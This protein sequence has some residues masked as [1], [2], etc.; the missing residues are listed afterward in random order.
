MADLLP[1]YKT[2]LA[3]IRT[4]LPRFHITNSQIEDALSEGEANATAEKIF[5]AKRRS[6]KFA[7][8]SDEEFWRAL[9]ASLIQ[10]AYESDTAAVAETQV[11]FDKLLDAAAAQLNRRWLVAL[12]VIGDGG[13]D[14]VHFLSTASAERVFVAG[15]SEGEQLQKQFAKA[16]ESFGITSSLPSIPTRINSSLLLVEGRGTEALALRQATRS[17]NVCRDASRLAVHFQDERTTLDPAPLPDDQSSLIDVL[18]LDVDQNQFHTRIERNIDTVLGAIRLLSNA[19]VRAFYDVAA[20]ILETCSEDTPVKNQIHL[21]WRL[22]RSIRVFSRA[23][24]AMNA[25]IRYLLMIV[26]MET[27]LNRPDAPITE[28]LSEYGALISTNDVNARIQLA[29]QLRSAYGFRSK[30]VHEGRLPTQQSDPQSFSN[31]L[32][33]VFQT[34]VKLMKQL[35][36]IAEIG[37]TDDELFARLLR[38]KFGA[39]FEDAFTFSQV[40]T[41]LE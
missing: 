30:F 12:P 27:L 6:P 5:A 21:I 23:V 19:R 39:T 34:W 24:G 11:V 20:R 40:T 17:L 29:K 4:S 16:A 1:L 41:P 28:S 14:I 38:L 15:E 35:M 32:S 37:L 10:T 33:I 31:I 9:T 8:F 22:A 7:Q 26:A 2:L 36:P 3:H 18:M 13:G 25:D